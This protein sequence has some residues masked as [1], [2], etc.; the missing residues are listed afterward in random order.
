[1]ALPLFVFV[2]VFSLLLLLLPFVFGGVDGVNGVSA[3]DVVFVVCCVGGGGC[4]LCG[5]EY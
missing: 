2:L 1:M 4:C 5:C 3:A